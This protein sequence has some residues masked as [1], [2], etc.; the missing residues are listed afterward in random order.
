MTKEGLTSLFDKSR[1]RCFYPISI[2]LSAGD[3]SVISR[4]YT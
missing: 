2:L 4:M 3:Y 1:S